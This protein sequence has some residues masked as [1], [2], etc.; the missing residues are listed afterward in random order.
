MRLEN[1]MTETKN[2][3]PINNR[4][5]LEELKSGEIVSFLK[6]GIMRYNGKIDNL[7][8]FLGR[9][10]GLNIEEIR[11][12]WF[13]KEQLK[14]WKGELGHIKIY[15]ERNYHNIKLEEERRAYESRDKFLKDGGL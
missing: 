1:K 12:L 13:T 10:D 4:K 2:Y 7:Y 11:E 6:F 8:N 14:P 3:K 15:A 5:D 9:S